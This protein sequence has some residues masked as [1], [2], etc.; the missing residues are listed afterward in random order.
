[1]I[2]QCSVCNKDMEEDYEP[3]TCCTGFECGCMGRII[4]PIVCSNECFDIV[5]NMSNPNQPQQAGEI[6]AFLWVGR[7]GW[8]EMLKFVCYCVCKGELCALL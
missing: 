1:M 5:I 8:R 2:Y 6:R 3:L 4:E 7:A